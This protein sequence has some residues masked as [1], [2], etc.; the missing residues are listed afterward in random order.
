MST[1]LLREGDEHHEVTVLADDGGSAHVIVDG[2]DLVLALR[3]LP[4]GTLAVTSR[5]Q[6]RRYRSFDDGRG[7]TLSEGPTQRRFDVMDE[8]ESWLQAGGAGGADGGGRIEASMPGRVVK[9]AVQEGQV[10]QAGDVV[11]VLEAMKM[12]NDVK[13]KTGG[14]VVEIG[15]TP[16]EAV[17]TGQLL[18]R[19][20]LAE[21]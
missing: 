14:L 18:V 1:Y 12:E 21:G 10:V 9:I 16:G 5:R 13:C 7:L 15:A 17:E 8:R 19:L 20:E 6:T 4:D 3:P 2:E 11:A